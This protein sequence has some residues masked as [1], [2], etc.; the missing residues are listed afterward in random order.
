MMDILVKELNAMDQISI[1]TQNSEY[2]FQ[3][4][5][6]AQCRGFISGG[7]FGNQRYE[8]ILTATMRDRVGCLSTKLETGA[9]ALF[10]ISIKET[11]RLLT[12]SVITDLSLAH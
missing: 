8:A 2:K 3:V 5:N 7:K 4:I 6:P 1:R 11:L 10:Y 9:C 12:T